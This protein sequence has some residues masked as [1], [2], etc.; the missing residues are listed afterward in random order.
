MATDKSIEI[1]MTYQL[2]LYNSRII[3]ASDSEYTL[4]GASLAE[5]LRPVPNYWDWELF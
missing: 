3:R 5:A 2:G 4:P 1:S